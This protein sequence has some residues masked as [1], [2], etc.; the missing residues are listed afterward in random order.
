MEKPAESSLAPSARML[1]MVAR[2]LRH[3][4]GDVLQT[5]YSAI[6]ILKS[7]LPADAAAERRLLVE[8]QTQAETCKH[9]LDAVQDLTCPLALNRAPTNLGDV[10]LGLVGRI[11]PRFPQV[12]LDLEAPRSLPVVADGLRLSQVGHLLLINACQAAQREVRVRLAPEAGDYIEWGITDDGPGVNAEQ[13]SWLTDPFS[14]THFA[15]FGLGLALARRIAELHGGGV[16][17]GNLPEGGFR[18]V[19]RLP[20]GS[21]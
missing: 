2:T 13:L 1:Q 7:R 4:V 19:L 3:E 12:R 21:A 9:K 10:L 11:G 5:V 8:L 18:V 6:A 20:A 16:S 17:A 14:T 15:Q